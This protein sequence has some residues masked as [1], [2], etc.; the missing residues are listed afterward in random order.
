MGKHTIIFIDFTTI[1][2]VEKTD[3][4]IQYH[5][6]SCTLPDEL[7][8]SLLQT[9]VNCGRVHRRSDGQS[10]FV[11]CNPPDLITKCS[12]NTQRTPVYLI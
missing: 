12:P 8:F 4:Y 9:R 10:R 2:E 3:H 7:E 1:A 6:Q 5:Y 11:M